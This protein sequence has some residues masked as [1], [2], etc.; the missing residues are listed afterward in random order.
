MT[1]TFLILI[2]AGGSAAALIAAF[3]FQMMGY[4]PCHLCWLQRYPHM[5]AV[6]IGVLALGLKGRTLPVLGALAALT[7]AGIGVYHSGVELKWWEGPTTCTSSSIGGMTPEQLL[8]QINGA[9]L[10]RCDE[11]AWQ[12]LGL[13]MANWN[14]ILSVALA[15]I[16]LAAARIPPSRA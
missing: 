7:T 16:W 8:A 6:G 10:V 3:G 13:S 15:L 5:A 4:A 14:V 12:F 11:I 2:A 1:R 9:A